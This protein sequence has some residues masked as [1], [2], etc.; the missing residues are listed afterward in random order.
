MGDG[1]CHQLLND[2]FKIVSWNVRGLNNADKQNL[3][4]GLL[5]KWKAD[6]VCLQEAKLEFWSR[7]L[8]GHLKFGRWMDYALWKLRGQREV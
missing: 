6:I 3:V 1:F 7:K 4:K 8:A 2:E 5:F